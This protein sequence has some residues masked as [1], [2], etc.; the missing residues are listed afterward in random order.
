MLRTL[1][2]DNLKTDASLD[3]LKGKITTL[4]LP[5]NQDVAI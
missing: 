5:S 1:T 4:T 2:E 3:G